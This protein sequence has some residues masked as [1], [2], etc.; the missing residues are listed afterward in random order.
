MKV[1]VLIISLC[2]TRFRYARDRLLPLENTNF[3][4]EYCP[5]ISGSSIESSLFERA[6]EFNL[7]RFGRSITREELGCSLAH[8]KAW[9][10]AVLQQTPTIVLED[11]FD[12]SKDARDVL[13]QALSSLINIVSSMD[14]V[15]CY[16]GGM[17]GYEPLLDRILLSPVAFQISKEITL[18]RICP[19]SAGLLFRTVSYLVTPRSASRLLSLSAKGIFVADRYDYIAS[20]SPSIKIYLTKLFVHPTI[21]Q[22]SIQGSSSLVIT[23]SV[24]MRRILLNLINS[25]LGSVCRVKWIIFIRMFSLL[26][27]TFDSY[28]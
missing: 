2:E 10:H 25:V 27:R 7:K 23:Q 15:L 17:E 13:P 8:R 6:V 16:L 22:S 24:G 9:A 5:A 20:S 19:A 28:I 4:I 21:Y 3:N 26:R 12:V 18:R 11:D 1:S 14:E